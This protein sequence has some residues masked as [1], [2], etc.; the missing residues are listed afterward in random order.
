LRSAFEIAELP[1]TP[2]FVGMLPERKDWII[3]MWWVTRFA[4]FLYEVP[5][6]LSATRER[7]V[8]YLG[9]AESVLGRGNF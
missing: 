9:M 2:T 6:V 5:G 1:A 3:E 8:S 7:Y 4:R